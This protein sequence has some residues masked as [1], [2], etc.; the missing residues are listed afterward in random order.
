M[1]CI[2]YLRLM[3]GIINAEELIKKSRG[4]RDQNASIEQIM[5]QI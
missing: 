4:T 5:S 1:V 2:V 3:V